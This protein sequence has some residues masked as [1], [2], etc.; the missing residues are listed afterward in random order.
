[1]I[2]QVEVPMFLE[3][4]LPEISGQL[5]KNSVKDTY[6]MIGALAA[7]TCRN[8]QAHNYDVTKRCF[9]VADKLYDKGNTVVK[10]AVE[11]V[12]VYSFTKMFRNA[13]EDKQLLQGMV[14]MTLYSL[15]MMQVYHK[16]C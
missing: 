13:H 9:A 11:N 7:F 3:E 15:Y 6:S 1:M 12:F 10:N 2:N 5:K 16:G 8:V 14:P 4:A